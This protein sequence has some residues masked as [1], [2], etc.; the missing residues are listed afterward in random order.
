M[1]A[2][3]PLV[4]VAGRFQQLPAGDYVPV[5][6]GGTG[7]TD[8]A[9]ARDALGITTAL[10]AKV[11]KV[12]GKQLST[13]DYSAAE[14]SK[15]AGLDP[16]H[17]RGMFATLAALQ[18]AVPAANIGDYAFVDPASGADVIQY[19]WDSNDG[20]WVYNGPTAGV[21]AAQVKTLYESNPNTNAFTDAD[22]SKLG[23]IAPGAQVNA[24]SS[25]A[26]RTGD[27]TLG[28][29]DVGLTNV[30]NLSA[31]AVRR[32]WNGGFNRYTT[33]QTL[34]AAQVGAVLWFIVANLSCALP[35]P[36][37]LVAGQGFTIRNATSGT[38]TITTPSGSIYPELDNFNAP[39]IVLGP[40]EWVEIGTDGTNWTFN[41][42]GLLEKAA[43][44]ASPSF[45]GGVT[46]TAS[47]AYR[48]INGNY[49]TF[50]F[51]DGA[52]LYLMVT[53]SGDQNGTFNAFRPFALNLA[54]GLL[55]IGGNGLGVSGPATFNNTV[56]VNST[57]T[58]TG[59]ISVAGTTG[60][61]KLRINGNAATNR[62]VRLDTANVQ[63]WQVGASAASESGSNIGSNFYINRFDDTGA[64]LSS[65]MTIDRASG[66]IQLSG[67][68]QTTGPFKPGSYTTTTLPSA[69]LFNGYMILVTNAQGG[70]KY[71]V[72]NGTVWQLFNTTT[73]VS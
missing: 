24:V 45:T 8:A 18:A 25:V 49:G 6:A 2:R 4:R 14:K 39:T 56:Q 63:R 43:P 73:T 34:T 55:S 40:K 9:G 44:L 64:Y 26:G 19:L 11:D 72:S 47:S 15:L 62:Y 31:M 69:A 29:G 51:Q 17:F 38:L 22:K 13:E 59:D 3:L 65:P 52:A 36:S 23:G 20:K 61:P 27:V 48:Q 5:V 10:S 58:A 21:T 71:C 37:S 32:S 53:N 7:A 41:L 33:S 1:G 66:D 46:L 54:T 50:W 35:S 28:K 60:E 16:N 30:D 68:V 70:A 67:K 12:A 42:R 57:L